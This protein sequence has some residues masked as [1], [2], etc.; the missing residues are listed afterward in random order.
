MTQRQDV[1]VSPNETLFQFA[2][3]GIEWEMDYSE[4]TPAEKRIWKNAD[5]IARC[6]RGLWT[7]RTVKVGDKKFYSSG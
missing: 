2:M 4:A 5:L 7:R 3:N 1:G 6:V